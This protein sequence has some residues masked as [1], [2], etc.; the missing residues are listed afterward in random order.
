MCR[1]EDINTREI[2]LWTGLQIEY[3]TGM[4]VVLLPNVI[5]SITGGIS[6]RTFLGLS[7]TGEE[8]DLRKS[9]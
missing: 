1:K 6:A 3:R 2:G 8:I 5:P 4:D 7:T 9:F